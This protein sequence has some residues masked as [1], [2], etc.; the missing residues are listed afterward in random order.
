MAEQIA[1]KDKDPLSGVKTSDENARF[2]SEL[3]LRP[4][5][6]QAFSAASEAVP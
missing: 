3:K 2:M 1:E 6:K 4:P 5:E